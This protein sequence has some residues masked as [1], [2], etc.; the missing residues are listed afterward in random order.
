[1]FLIEPTE[2]EY[3]TKTKSP[4]KR[5]PRLTYEELEEIA[6]KNGVGD[7]HRRIIEELP[8]Y[9]DLAGTTRSSIAF[10]GFDK[11]NNSRMTI[12]SIL[13]G[14]SSS[15]K[16]MRYTVYM[17]RFTD[18]FKVDREKAKIILPSYE[19]KIGYGEWAGE[20]GGGYFTDESQV[21]N[22]LKSLAEIERKQNGEIL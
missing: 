8:K 20:F 15:E 5:K 1:V 2:V 6:E 10:V 12:L 21:N 18:Y 14:E 7:I 9:F 13:P 22:F 17:D 4:S 19:R 11:E 3:R 16:G